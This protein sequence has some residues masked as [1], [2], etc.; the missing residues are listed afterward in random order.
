[1]A[2]GEARLDALQHCLKVRRERDRQQQAAFEVH[3]GFGPHVGDDGF[4]DIS[5][6]DPEAVG[7]AM[8]RSIS[9]A[10]TS[11]LQRQL[12]DAAIKAFDAGIPHADTARYLDVS[13]VKV[14]RWIADEVAA[15]LPDGA[16]DV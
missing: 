1:M 6:L 5:A 10:N 9:A 11:E 7:K 15:R 13:P 4:V 2:E 12:R 16:S 3:G 14:H 8:A